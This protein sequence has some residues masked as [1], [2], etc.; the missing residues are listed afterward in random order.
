MPLKNL[1]T[2]LNFVAELMR[3]RRRVHRGE[4][5]PSLVYGDALLR[6]RLVRPATDALPP[7]IVVIGPTQAGKSTVVNLLLGSEQA[8]ISSLAGFTRHPQAYTAR[9]VDA[10]LIT[11][12]ERLLE[13]LKYRPLE[14]LRD[15]ELESFSVKQVDGQKKGCSTACLLWDTP[16]FDSVSSRSYRSA[17]PRLCALADL[18]VLVVSA[19][20]YADQSVWSL[21]R[22]IGQV[23]Q[24]LLVCL[25]KT[26]SRTE[27]ALVE[28]VK[29]KFSR[30]QVAQIG[31]IPVTFQ[32]NP[33]FEKLLASGGAQQLR[34]SVEAVVKALG[35]GEVA[36]RPVADYLKRHWPHWTLPLRQE[37]AARNRWRAML[38]D[39]EKEALEI[40]QRDYLH[41]PD[42]GDTMQRAVARLLELLEIPGAA[43]VL[44]RTRN[45]LTWPARTLIGMFRNEERSRSKG[46]DH[47]A[48]VL[49]AALDH[50]L[51]GLQRQVGQQMSAAAEETEWW[52]QLWLVLGR[53]LAEIEF[54]GKELIQRHQRA[55]EPRIKEAGEELYS[56]LQEHPSI[57]NGLRAARVTVDAT[58]V[59]LA[60]KTGGLGANDL[61]FAPAMLSITSMLTESAMGRYMQTIEQRLKAQQLA[62]VE[63]ELFAPLRQQLDAL[64]GTINSEHLYNID[65]QRLAEAERALAGL[66]QE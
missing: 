24:P 11:A 28:A 33:A 45:L 14:A 34:G 37:H 56:H 27:Q 7:Q 6:N 8:Q 3:C 47:E 31:I 25:N 16:D 23:E 59:V 17:V 51:L 39:A 32:K 57:L 26:T 41:D 19:E 20:K 50:V 18:V 61:I 15:D 64:A 10:P 54:H 43:A 22:L 4:D 38:G 35:G 12:L 30:E 13:G 46:A 66:E 52:R 58:A 21:L 42:Y 5:D 9:S 40:Y 48:D 2:L 63:Q 53:H 49:G 65:E 29:E 44:A 1:E 55:F 36:I 60:I 62:S